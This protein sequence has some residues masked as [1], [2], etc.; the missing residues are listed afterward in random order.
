MTY[1][2]KYLG[3]VNIYVRNADVSEKF[4]SDLLGLHINERRP[5]QAVF[6]SADQEQSHEIALMQLGPDALAR[7]DGQ[8]GLNHIAWRMET[9][10]DLKEVY[11]RL[12]GRDIE[13][14]VADHGISLGVYFRDPDGNGNEVYYELPKEQWPQEGQ[15]FVGHFPMSLEDEPTDVKAT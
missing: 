4:Y 10:D 2:P 9:L 6:M 5:G 13:T 11:G 1:K 8:V 15:I 3:H 12:K 14:K 7:E